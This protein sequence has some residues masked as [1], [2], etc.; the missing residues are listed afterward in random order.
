[1]KERLL[2]LVGPTAVG[3]SAVSVGV[4]R[5]LGAEIISGDSM[6]V[7]RGM[8]IGTAKVS[9]AEMGGV[10]HHLLDIKSP[11]QSF[12][13]AEFRQR[14]DG[15]IREIADRGRLP[16]LVGGTGLYVRSVLQ[17]YSFTDEAA[18]PELRAE[19]AAAETEH[20]PG[21]LHRRLAEVDP[22][23]AGRL[24]PND[25]RR[26]IRA[27]EVF[28]VTGTRIS[29]TQTAAAAAPRYDHL[30]IGMTMAR[31]ELYRRIDG[32]VERMFAA[33][34]E[35]EVTSLLRSYHPSVTAMQAIGY[36][37]LALYRRGL[38][39][40]VEA[41]ALIKR[42]TR[43]F[44]KRQLT[45]FRRE[46]DLVWLDATGR[47]VESLVEEIASMAEGKWERSVEA[48]RRQPDTDAGQSGGLPGE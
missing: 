23:A 38:I 29:A 9:S 34:L 48:G 15:L 6:Q 47:T 17:E 33:G 1:M 21:Y 5:R 16:F 13:V 18:D 36:A 20:G 10:V 24:H 8:D 12:S 42:N 43:R 37:E 26:V 35:D 46:R 19:L 25:L 7:Y 3:K 14:V 27:L 4:A 22:E 11:D 44:A 45:W 30:L 41:I 40:R 28:R 32:R 2:V 31:A 39:S